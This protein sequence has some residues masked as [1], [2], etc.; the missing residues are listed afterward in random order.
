MTVRKSQFW[1][2]VAG[3]LMVTGFLWLL[4]LLFA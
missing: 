1:A 4:W 3:T 2:D